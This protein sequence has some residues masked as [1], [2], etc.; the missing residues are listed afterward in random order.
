MRQFK[1]KIVEVK[2]PL[3]DCSHTSVS[4]R[5]AWN[6]WLKDRFPSAR[7]PKTDPAFEFAFEFISNSEL[8]YS[9]QELHFE[10]QRPETVVHKVRTPTNSSTRKFT[11]NADSQANSRLKG[12]ETL[13]AGPRNLFGQSTRWFW[14][15]K[16]TA[17]RALLQVRSVNPGTAVI[18]TCSLDWELPLWVYGKINTKFTSTD[19]FSS[20][21]LSEPGS[22][23]MAWG[24]RMLC[25]RQ[26]RTHVAVLNL[27]S[28]NLGV[29][30]CEMEGT[31]PNLRWRCEKQRWDLG[32]VCVWHTAGT[33][34]SS[35]FLCNHDFP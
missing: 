15:L 11:K 8:K 3:D 18:L 27:T 32:K 28:L 21:H 26:T 20:I 30:T 10:K 13:E 23:L 19:R 5:I 34:L 2:N 14:K 1:S 16:N 12:S 9:G 33:G 4:W 24:E 17:L 31:A 6:I 25:F 7:P 35:Q 22:E 29:F